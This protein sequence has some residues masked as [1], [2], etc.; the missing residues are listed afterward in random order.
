MNT[1]WSQPKTNI[2][3]GML[4]L[5]SALAH[6]YKAKLIRARNE[7]CQYPRRTKNK[8]TDFRCFEFFVGYTTSI[9]M[10]NKTSRDDYSKYLSLNYVSMYGTDA[11]IKQYYDTGKLSKD[12]FCS[13]GRNHLV[14]VDDYIRYLETNHD[15]RA[16]MYKLQYRNP[17]STGT[18]YFFDFYRLKTGKN[19]WELR[20]YKHKLWVVDLLESPALGD[21]P[22]I[23]TAIKILNVLMYPLKY[24]PRRNVLRMPEYTNV[25]FRVGGVINGFSVQFQLPKKFGFK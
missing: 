24:V 22:K 3:L 1:N 5:R 7:D 16:N 8:N 10:I 4:D 2:L 23:P 18:S 15:S 19:E 12:N 6:G 21:N 25:T 9:D 11:A 14:H 13:A 17:L 20:K